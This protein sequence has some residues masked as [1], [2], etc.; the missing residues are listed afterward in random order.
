MI[1]KIEQLV[2][3]ADI[4][5]EG[6]VNDF[7]KNLVMFKTV[8]EGVKIELEN[9]EKL[10]K[11]MAAASSSVASKLEDVPEE[12]WP[13][14]GELYETG[15]VDTPDPEAPIATQVEE[16]PKKRKRRTKEEMAAAKAAMEKAEEIEKKI[17]E[18]IEKIEKSGEALGV[19]K[20]QVEAISNSV[21]Q[22]VKAKEV[23]TDEKEDWE[24]TLEDEIN[25]VDEVEEP[26]ATKEELLTDLLNKYPHPFNLSHLETK[27]EKT[28]FM[29]D[30]QAMKNLVGNETT[31]DLKDKLLKVD[32]PENDLVRIGKFITILPA[33]ELQVK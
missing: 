19:S 14:S 16:A 11:G 24:K 33:L 17:D 4:L 8:L 21:S 26:T 32:L 3:V 18:T 9:N 28:S 7:P 31:K 1:K 23:N 2:R 29:E 20:E 12:T 15:K 5:I 10:K 25:E 13:K 22:A 30:V 27:A 6:K